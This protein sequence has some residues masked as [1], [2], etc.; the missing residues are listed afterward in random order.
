LS[1]AGRPRQEARLEGRS[2]AAVEPEALVGQVGL[3]EP[4]GRVDRAVRGVPAGE[5][6]LVAMAVESMNSPCSSLKRTLAATPLTLGPLPLALQRFP[7]LLRSS[8]SLL[9][10]DCSG[11]Q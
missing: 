1:Q 5:A 4:V 9:E 10:S 11:A 8:S 7:G 2:G 6:G 3:V